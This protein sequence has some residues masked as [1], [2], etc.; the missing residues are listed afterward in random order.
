MQR[1][2][3]EGAIRQVEAA[4]DRAWTEGDVDAVVACLTEDAIVVSP[5]GEVARG[6]TEVR[7]L[8]GAFLGGEAR[9]S[10]HTTSV[11]RIAL[12]TDE[13]AVVDGVARVSVRG[14]PSAAPA[15]SLRH[16]FTDVLVRRSTGWRIAHVRAYSLDAPA[17][18][19]E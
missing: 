10:Q 19:E 1:P 9:G 13:V 8:L 4:Y 6:R 3:A 15:L 12:V 18:G 7:A 2:A 11:V 14:H 17:P 5:R 16:G